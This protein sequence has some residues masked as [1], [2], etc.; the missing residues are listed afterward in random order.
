MILNN[1]VVHVRYVLIRKKLLLGFIMLNMFEF[2]GNEECLHIR[3][4]LQENEEE[5]VCHNCARIVSVL[6]DHYIVFF[7]EDSD[8]KRAQKK[9]STNNLR[10]AAEGSALPILNTFEARLG[11]LEALLRDVP[12]DV[13]NALISRLDASLNVGPGESSSEASNVLRKVSS[14]TIAKMPERN[15]ASGLEEIQRSLQGLNLSNGYLYLD[16]IGQTK[17]Q[18]KQN[19][20]KSAQRF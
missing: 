18:G 1:H 13:H 6:S 4:A 19:F 11:S 9:A 17:W 15:V 2:T 5:K 3:I 8:G 16:E 14:R 20:Q 7:R 12:P 10:L